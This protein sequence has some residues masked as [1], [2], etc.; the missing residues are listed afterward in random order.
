M[1]K[2]RRLFTLLLFCIAGCSVGVGDVLPGPDTGSPSGQTTS[3]V[4]SGTTTSGAASGSAG[5]SG[6]AGSASSS[7]TAGSAGSGTAGSG[8]ETSPSTGSDTG[9]GTTASTGIPADASD[10]PFD[11][12]TRDGAAEAARPDTGS[13][14]T[15]GGA[16]AYG[17]PVN[18][19][20]SFTWYY[21]GQ[22]TGQQNGKYLTACGYQG[23]ESGMIDTVEN[24]ASSSPA[25]STYFA[26][27]PGS[28]GFSTVSDCGACVEITNGNT[29]IVATI[30]DECPT[31]NGQNPNCTKPNHLDLSYG[32][33]QALHYANGDPSGTTWKFVACP[34]HGTIITR[35]KDGNADQVYIENTPF[36]IASVTF[37]RA[38]AH[39]LG[40]GAWQL[41]NGSPVAGATLTLED[42]QGNMVTVVVPF[43]GGDTG[44]QFSTGCN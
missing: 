15:P 13:G 19:S 29:S 34:V 7:G 25:S 38:P 12:A 18:G 11:A 6:T 27:I 32:A 17:T 39:H 21:F 37:A 8:V 33:W 9:S 2:G 4:P 43:N 3:S 35:L 1:T 42:V 16:C 24:I 5:S 44:Q 10:D 22:G 40:Y 30:I 14:T 26:A 31:D 20:G 36:P 23:T 28:G 41:P